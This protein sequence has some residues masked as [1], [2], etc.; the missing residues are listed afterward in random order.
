MADQYFGRGAFI[1]LVP[2]VTYGTPVSPRTHFYRI[3]NASLRRDVAKRPRNPLHTSGAVPISRSHFRENDNVSGSI[4]MEVMFENVGLILRHLMGSSSDGLLSGGHYIHTYQLAADLLTGLTI[5]LGRGTGTSEV[6]SGI[7]LNRGVF[8]VEAGG[9]MTLDLDVIGY[10]S[11]GRVGIGTPTHMTSEIPILHHHA[12]ELSFN[13]QTYA[14]R[15]FELVIDN[16]LARRQQLGTV[17]TSEPKRAN[18]VQ[19]EMNVTLEV[20]DAWTA[21]EIADTEGDATIRFTDDVDPARYLEFIM[22]NAF[23]DDATDPVNEPG[24]LITN[25]KL[26]AQG[27]GTDHGLLISTRVVAATATDFV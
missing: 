2:E 17:Y 21:A 10:S 22:H 20:D 8:K 13:A 3:L 16:Q 25:A 18:P 12:G 1:G 7:K 11:A 9:Q 23:V 27:D 14:L 24:M 6:F 26:M 19:L 4:S 5:D 15:S